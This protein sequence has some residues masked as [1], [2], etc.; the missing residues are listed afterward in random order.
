MNNKVCELVCVCV[1]VCVCLC[2]CIC[3]CLP[4]WVW[5]DESVWVCVRAHDQGTYRGVQRGHPGVP[6]GPRT[7]RNLIIS[8]IG[9]WYPRRSGKCGGIVATIINTQFNFYDSKYLPANM[10]KWDRV[11][12]LFLKNTERNYYLTQILSWTQ[13]W[14]C[15]RVKI[16]K[17]FDPR[18][19]SKKGLIPR[20]WL[21]NWT[22]SIE[23]THG[24]PTWTTK[25]V[26]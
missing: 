26:S 1:C 24:A 16:R 11:R 21:L 12:S 7:D 14:P 20:S 10:C 22:V 19:N 2:V 3:V 8:M 18:P 17:F 6:G 4:V 5:V 23:G 9:I 13:C 15:T 25:C